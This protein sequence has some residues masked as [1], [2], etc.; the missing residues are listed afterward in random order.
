MEKERSE[1]DA[2]E[3]EDL[4]FPEFK[5]KKEKEAEGSVQ[6]SLQP[7]IVENYD[8]KLALSLSKTEAE[9]KKKAMKQHTGFARILPPEEAFEVIKERLN[10]I[11]HE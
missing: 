6:K 11:Y 7:E 3:D 9:A 2:I 10:L 8:L 4:K 5:S 1:K